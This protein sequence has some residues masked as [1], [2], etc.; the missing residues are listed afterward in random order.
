MQK[1]VDE[2]YTL[3]KGKEPYI[4]KNSLIISSNAKVASIV[5]DEFDDRNLTNALKNN[6]PNNKVIKF[7]NDSNFKNDILSIIDNYDNIIVYSYDAYKD[8]V[9]KETIN[10]LYPEVT[11]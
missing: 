4:T 5:E 11:I 6:F 10:E 3:I 9:Q 8:N 7:N 1:I 2:S